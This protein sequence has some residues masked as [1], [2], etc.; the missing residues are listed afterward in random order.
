MHK[1]VLGKQGEAFVADYLIL[2]GFSIIAQNYRTSFGEI[3]LIVHK[4]NV[5]AFVEVKLRTQ[6]YIYMSEMIPVSKQR[7]ITKTAAHFLSTTS[8]DNCIIRFDAVLLETTQTGFRVDYYEHAFTA[9]G[10][11]WFHH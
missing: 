1:N 11:S 2:K 3:D 7:K 8:F 10:D 9:C 6:Q 4:N 5:L